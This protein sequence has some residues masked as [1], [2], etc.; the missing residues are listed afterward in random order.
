[1]SLKKD[2]VLVVNVENEAAGCKLTLTA[3][4][5]ISPDLVVIKAEDGVYKLEE[6]K[7]AVKQA[8]QFSLI[9]KAIS[10]QRA[11]EKEGIDGIHIP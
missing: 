8:E 7:E 2:D 10:E 5:A 6:L 11:R 1:M 3:T 4:T 9:Q